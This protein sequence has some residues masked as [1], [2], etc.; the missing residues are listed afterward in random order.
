VQFLLA[1][2]R[3]SIPS[4]RRGY[5]LLTMTVVSV[6]SASPS[7]LAQETSTG[8]LP[9]GLT[10]LPTIR[11]AN[12][13]WDDNIFR[14]SRTED[15]QGDFTA[16]VTPA[17]RASLRTR[18]VSLT[19]RGQLDFNYFKQFSDIRSIDSDVAGRGELALGRIT[20]YVG[21]EWTN[22][23]HRRGLEIDLPVRR[24]DYSWYGGVDLRVS[25]R[26][27]VGVMARRS[28][29]DYRGEAVFEDTDLEQYLG[30]TTW[31]EGLRMRYSVTPLTT[32]GIEV[33]RD[34]NTFALAPERDSDGVRVTSVVEFQP[35]AIVNGRAQVGIRRRSFADGAVPNFGGTVVRVD[36]GYTLLG[37]TRIGVTGRR[38]LAYSYR[39]DQRDY[40]Q[41]GFD[42]SVTHRLT[43]VWDVMGTLARYNLVYDLAAGRTRSERVFGYGVNVGYRVQRT[44]IGFQ[45]ARNVRTSDFSVGREYEGMQLTSSVSY[46]F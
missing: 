19:G 38:D 21:G 22:A 28:G 6:L 20:P 9:S 39:I 43:P 45:V 30:A 36:L 13:G 29:V 40:L 31:I 46:E 23:R 16:T 12:I 42:L 25:G 37:R 34:H 24:V 26:T 10:V 17:A 8:D 1:A 7:L 18:R 15:P 2:E 11:V 3:R 32:I 14:L 44:R 27:S 5:A 33:E 35:L 41:S 4:R